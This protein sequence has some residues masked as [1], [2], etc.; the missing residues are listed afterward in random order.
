MKLK[1]IIRIDNPEEYRLHFAKNSEGSEPLDSYLDSFEHWAGWNRYCA[2]GRD[3][4]PVRYIISF[5]NFYPKPGSSLFGGI[6]EVLARHWENNVEDNPSEFYDIRLVDD[7]KELIGRLR[8]ETPYT[9]QQTVVNL[10]KYDTVEVL[11]LLPAPYAHHVFPGYENI[12]YDSAII[13]KIIASDAHDWKAALS[14]VKGIYMLTDMNNGKKYIGAAYGD[15]GIWGRWQNYMYS[16]HGWNSELIKLYDEHGEEY[17]QNFK[18]TLLEVYSASTL[19][20]YI[21]RRE[22]YW[23]GVMLSRDERYG[24][25]D[26]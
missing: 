15:G 23:K 5:M 16:L 7:Y 26:N 21:I 22:N 14:S 8:V 4:F 24:Y 19:D 9:G 10:D 3:R 11:E 12:D 13:R 6:F 25:N 18:F 17:M 20:E 2:G 1:D